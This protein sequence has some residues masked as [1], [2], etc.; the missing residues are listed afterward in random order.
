MADVASRG[1]GASP[2]SRSGRRTARR[3]L[4]KSEVGFAVALPALVFACHMSFGA[5]RI[6][7]SL[8]YV[9]VFAAL[10]IAILATSWARKDLR[11]APLALPAALFSAVIAAALWALTPLTPEGPNPL[12][13]YAPRAFG[14]VVD[15]SNLT[16]ELI[17]LG[18]LACVFVA[19]YLIGADSQRARLAFQALV[20]LSIL[21]GLWAALAHI[22]EPRYVLGVG[23]RYAANRL[24]GSFLSP[25]TAA[26]LLGASLVLVLAQLLARWRAAGRAPAEILLRRIGFLGAGTVAIVTALLLTQS[27]AGIAATVVGLAVAL[28]L[29][30]F[31]GRWSWRWG[32]GLLLLAV[33]IGLGPLVVRAGQGAYARL[34]N[35]SQD[36]AGRQ[37]IFAAHWDAYQT[38][39]WFGYGLGSFDRINQMI[40]TPSN[41]GLLFD[42][43]AL[44]NVY[45]QWLEEAGAVGAGSM[46]LT[47]AAI[48]VLIGRGA[49]AREDQSV[50][51]RGALA[52]SVV[53]LVHG[54]SDFALQV[55]SMPIYWA[56][57]LGLAF[58]RVRGR[59]A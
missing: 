44:H 55:P 9:A 13:A 14:S 27:R 51:A 17:K 43:H 24:T 22:V 56:C 12:W 45:I 5:A 41:Y 58:G 19:A 53:I 37:A 1:G 29:H 48:L 57:L 30:A 33:V 38:A 18:G 15:V 10:L 26:T 23:K 8:I 11:L 21:Y 36:A 54:L 3:K 31:Q 25:N 32:G 46:F 34:E 39:P 7:V 59:R 6:A 49:V 47:I 42:V 4:R 2:T 40:M 16:I 20:V 35:L 52:A 50:I 28:A